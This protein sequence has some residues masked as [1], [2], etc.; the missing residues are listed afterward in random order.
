MIA[1]ATSNP[2]RQVVIDNQRSVTLVEI[3]LLASRSLADPATQ[4]VAEDVAAGSSLVVSLPKDGGCIY[5]IMGSFGDASTVSRQ[6]MDLC[7]DPTL[8][9]LDPGAPRSGADLQ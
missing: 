1:H 2:A 8:R 3:R 9:L 6:G 4:P 5:D 7:S